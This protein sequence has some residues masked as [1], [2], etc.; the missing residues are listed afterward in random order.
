MTSRLSHLDRALYTLDHYDPDGES[1]VVG[2][3][4]LAMAELLPVYEIR[5]VDV[6]ARTGLIRHLKDS[7]F[8]GD[9]SRTTRRVEPT[10]EEYRFYS[11]NRVMLEPRPDNPES[12]SLLPFQAFTGIEDKRYQMTYE[13]AEQD[14][15]RDGKTGRL[16]L[17]PDAIIDWKLRVDRPK[18]LEVASRAL[19][20]MVSVR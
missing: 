2:T 15:V 12:A 18:D 7:V 17:P 19:S 9:L 1:I 20:R 3:V 14:A 13:R 5:D 11:A 4:G 10:N 8:A 6:L 16:M